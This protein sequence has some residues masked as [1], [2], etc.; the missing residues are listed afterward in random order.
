MD[1]DQSNIFFK[2]QLHKYYIL[3]LYTA[4]NCSINTMDFK[5]GLQ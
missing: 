1:L 5:H 4:V 3:F 2:I